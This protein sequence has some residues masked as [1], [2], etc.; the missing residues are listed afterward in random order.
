MSICSSSRYV[1]NINQVSKR[2]NNSL[3]FFMRKDMSLLEL[4]SL[5]SNIIQNTIFDRGEFSSCWYHSWQESF[6]FYYGRVV[7]MYP[8]VLNEWRWTL[9]AAF[10]MKSFDFVYTCKDFHSQFVFPLYKESSK[11]AVYNM[12][13]CTHVIE[14]ESYTLSLSD[15]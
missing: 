3:H 14:K 5:W 7:A 13:T 9:Y 15:K 10:C 6:L 12:Y 1:K 4:I 11:M 2:S 8:L